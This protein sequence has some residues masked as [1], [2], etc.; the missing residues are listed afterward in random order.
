MPRPTESMTM[1]LEP[2]KEVRSKSYG[3]ISL[4]FMCFITGQIGI[5]LN[6]AWAEPLDPYDASDLAASETDMQFG[7]GWY[8]QPILM[9]GKYP[10]IM[11]EKV[12]TLLEHSFMNNI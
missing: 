11:R 9:D 2:P 1:N 6:S 12:C 10:S 3:I 7:L 4:C 8:A 5:T